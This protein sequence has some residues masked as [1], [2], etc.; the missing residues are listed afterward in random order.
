[1]LTTEESFRVVDKTSGKIVQGDETRREVEHCLLLE[2]KGS[3]TDKK[4]KPITLDD[5][6]ICDI[7]H[8]MEGNPIYEYCS[9]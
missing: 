9:M 2:A 3:I 5:W 7:D 4:G 8:I 6:V 1:M